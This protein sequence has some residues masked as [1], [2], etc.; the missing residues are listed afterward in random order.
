MDNRPR[1]QKSKSLAKTRSDDAST[2][3]PLP[4]HQRDHSLSP[5]AAGRCGAAAFLAGDRAPQRSSSYTIPA[6]LPVQCVVSPCCSS[7]L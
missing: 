6:I 1:A 2:L 7:P 3:N 4:E 5:S